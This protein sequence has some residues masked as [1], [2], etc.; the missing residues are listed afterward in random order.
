VALLVGGSLAGFV[1]ALLSL[2]VA[3]IVKIIAREL[4]V[5]DRIEEVKEADQ[6][7]SPSPAAHRRWRRC[8]R[9]RGDFPSGDLEAT[10]EEA[11]L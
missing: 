1:G 6:H 2:P 10:E 8:R 9:S 5:S 7:T 3:A 11:K 4:Y